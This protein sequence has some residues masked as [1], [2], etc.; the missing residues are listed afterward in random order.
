MRRITR[1]IVLLIAAAGLV[2]GGV[3]DPRDDGRGHSGW[4][5]GHSAHGNTAWG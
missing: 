3:G 1:S 4:G 2:I 5:P